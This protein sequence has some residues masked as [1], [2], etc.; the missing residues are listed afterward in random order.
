MGGGGGGKVCDGF[1]YLWEVV[2][3]ISTFLY[4]ISIEVA[5]FLG[6]THH[7]S[8]KF[9]IYITFVYHGILNRRKKIS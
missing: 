8:F 5:S 7:R 3:L 9:L 2:C 6:P 1:W 4:C